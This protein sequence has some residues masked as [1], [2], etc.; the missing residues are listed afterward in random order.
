[1]SQLKIEDPE[2]VELIDAGNTLNTPLF[3]GNRGTLGSDKDFFVHKI[4]FIQTD[5]PYNIG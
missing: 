2:L 5:F 3:G 1:M 4:E